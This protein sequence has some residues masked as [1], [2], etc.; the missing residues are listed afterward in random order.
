M[1]FHKLNLK[2][3]HK[4]PITCIQYHAPTSTVITGS[5]DGTIRQWHVQKQKHV[6]EFEGFVDDGKVSRT[7]TPEKGGGG[8]TV[9]RLFLDAEKK[10]L[11]AVGKQ[12]AKV[13]VITP[14]NKQE[15]Q[16]IRVRDIQKQKTKAVSEFK[17]AHKDKINSST[18]DYV[19]SQLFTAG[20]DFDKSCKQFTCGSTRSNN[21]MI[22]I[23]ERH[24]RAINILQIGPGLLATG[25][26]KGKM[27]NVFNTENGEHIC[28]IDGFRF[29]LTSILL[30]RHENRVY[31]G[32]KDSRKTPL[33]IYSLKS[34]EKEASID[35]TK[36]LPVPERKGGDV[37]K[38]TVFQPLN[39]LLASIGDNAGGSEK[40]ED[41]N[42]CIL[43]I[44]IKTSKVVCKMVGHHRASIVD[45]V[46]LENK[47]NGLMVSCGKDG[48]VN[49]WHLKTGSL[50]YT[51]K[52]HEE[53]IS[54][55]IYDTSD[56][57]VVTGSYD[58][59]Y[60]VYSIDQ[61]TII[62]NVKQCLRDLKQKRLKAQQEEASKAKLIKRDKPP[63]SSKTN[64]S[65]SVSKPRA[66]ENASS[67]S[68]RNVTVEQQI[69]IQ[70]NL[71]AFDEKQSALTKSKTDAPKKPKSNNTKDYQAPQQRNP[72]IK[73]K[74]STIHPKGSLVSVLSEK[75][76]GDLGQPGSRISIVL[77]GGD[78]IGIEFDD[79]LEDDVEHV[80][81]VVGINKRLGLKLLKMGDVILRINRIAVTGK[82]MHELHDIIENR[83]VPTKLILRHVTDEERRIAEAKAVTRQRLEQERILRKKAMLQNKIDSIDKK[84]A[85]EKQQRILYKERLQALIGKVSSD[86]EALKEAD[87]DKMI[88]KLKKYDPTSE[89]PFN[90][91]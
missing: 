31:V 46:C 71:D 42:H 12:L 64:K 72:T 1:N 85:H 56:N 62:K 18:Y 4:K 86:G 15:D 65:P 90:N 75:S 22:G 70:K 61:A 2:V 78:D 24:S 53:E 73:R 91:E 51:C 35:L 77:G 9:K 81:H 58:I 45:N 5:K 13:F 79:H 89:F 6:E 19:H 16:A 28:T 34:G 29:K 26:T 40:S 49:C 48:T 80:H 30:A 47:F 82:D 37:G 41:N 44:D 67:A 69:E 23:F 57:T 59:T 7:A 8:N 11:V 10:I 33:C 39:L 17:G 14:S 27:I 36:Q 20:G 76:I 52:G 54:Q 87:F 84:K 3:R 66:R 32:G 60:A 83:E 68:S 25:S 43:G 50:I 63:K 21:K 55:M 38:L 88:R 74:Q